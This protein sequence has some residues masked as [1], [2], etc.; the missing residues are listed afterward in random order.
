ME[1][2][3]EPDSINAEILHT[4][5][6]MEYLSLNGTDSITNARARC[7]RILES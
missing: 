4:R 1:V 6:D 5:H 7:I 3:E 2:V